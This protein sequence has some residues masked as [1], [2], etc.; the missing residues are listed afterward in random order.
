MNK[1]KA[2]SLW[3]VMKAFARGSKIQWYD[4]ESDSWR[5]H[6][7]PTF[8]LEHQW[9][10]KPENVAF[11]DWWTKNH[12]GWPKTEKEIALKAWEEALKIKP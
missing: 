11:E 2:E 10:I 8:A 5:D 4:V 7:N 9:R 6:G 1:L 12:S 3:P